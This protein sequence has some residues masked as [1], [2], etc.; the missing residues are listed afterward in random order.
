MK[1]TFNPTT[2]V[3][4]VT[5][6]ENDRIIQ[7]SSDNYVYL[8]GVEAGW[9]IKA[10][11]TRRDNVQIGLIG[12]VY[13]LD[14][15]DEYCYIIPIPTKAT[16]VD[17]GLGL[18]ILIYEPSGETFI[19]HSTIATSMY[20]YTSTNVIV[21]DDLDTVLYDAVM[22]AISN[23]TES[24]LEHEAIVGITGETTSKN[25]PV[26]SKQK[27]DELYTIAMTNT[28]TH[29]ARTDNPH[30]TTKAQVGLGNA[31]NTSDVNKPV[32]TDQAAA[33]ALKL[34]K[35]L[36]SLT[37]GGQIASNDLIYV[38]TNDGV[39]TKVAGSELT[40]LIKTITM[41]TSTYVLT[42]TKY[43]GTQTTIDLPAEMAFVS[44]SYSD[45]TED[46]T[47]TLQNG[48]TVTVPL[49][50]L[51]S[52]LAS[53]DWVALYF[54]DK[55]E[56]DAKYEVLTN[57]ATDFSVVNDTK[58]PTTKAVAE[59]LLNLPITELNNHTLREVYNE[60]ETSYTI[61]NVNFDNYWVRI[62]T[63]ETFPHTFYH[64]E[65]IYDGI[66]SN[67]LYFS[68]GSISFRWIT[69]T[70]TL[71][72]IDNTLFYDKTINYLFDVDG[73]NAKKYIIDMGLY[74][75]NSVSNERM[76]FWYQVFKSINLNGSLAMVF[77]HLITFENEYRNNYVEAKLLN[78]NIVCFGDSIT[79]T[80]DGISANSAYPD[81]MKET[82]K[83][84]VYNQGYSSGRTA[85]NSD[86]IKNSFSLFNLWDSIVSEDYT[87]QDTTLFGVSGYETQ[88]D[89][90]QRLK[91]IDFNTVDIVTIAL[92]TNDWAGSVPL[93]DNLLNEFDT[94]NFYGATRYVI[95]KILD[96]FPHIKIM[97]IS[98]IYRF[99]V[100]IDG[101]TILNYAETFNVNSLNIFEY[102]N[103]IL[104]IAKDFNLPRVDMCKN[105]GINKYNCVYYFKN[106]SNTYDGTHPNING[107]RLMG[108]LI[109]G[110]L[111]KQF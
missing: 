30:S 43:D 102:S 106:N 3:Q 1:I 110:E 65:R 97:I 94:T 8:Y 35:D 44:A 28:N 82:L 32:S 101:L 20:V 81:V 45:V 72:Q 18:S 31:D 76:L 66:T 87:L 75:I 34:S 22:L 59:R 111:T 64:E 9:E 6:S 4:V 12:G 99:E 41:N 108:K 26:Y 27:I 84:N 54:Y 17:K 69:E 105:L 71:T 25:T 68:G 21:P 78:K 73:I 77:N 38:Y 42:I 100:D 37:D 57:K 56:T 7:N 90:V 96:N 15:D 49:D 29:K 55:T 93:D 14:P 48:S 86:P 95:K 39:P 60:N 92:G 103:G 51:V 107:K 46:L 13:G 74:G 83:A 2:K 23:L 24:K 50:D 98:P 52:G 11:F 109:S 70:E 67:I 89:A 10:T 88:Y 58:Y 79:A 5:P 19:R 80:G 91:L 61:N 36:S 53:E 47:F 62:R 104:D 40:Q 85:Y 16:E 33:I 63:P